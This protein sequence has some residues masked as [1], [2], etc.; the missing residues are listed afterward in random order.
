MPESPQLTSVVNEA[1]KTENNTINQIASYNK[2]VKNLI[3]VVSREN[4][5]E[6]IKN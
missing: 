6:K 3:K 1:Q 2:N 5:I 4:E